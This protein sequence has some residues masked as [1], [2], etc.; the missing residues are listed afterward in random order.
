MFRFYF[1]LPHKE[2]LLLALQPLP[3]AQ[4]PNTVL[5]MKFV[6]TLASEALLLPKDQRLTLAHRILT[7]VETDADTTVDEAW[8]SEIRERIKRYDAAAAVAV[9]GQA[10]FAELDNQ[11]KK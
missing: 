4:K 6:D 10:V 9:P 1:F 5:H 8:D 7:S 2:H 3:S 11:I